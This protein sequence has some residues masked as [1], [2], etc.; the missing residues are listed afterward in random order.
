MQLRRVIEL[1][2]AAAAGFCVLGL[3]LP[4]LLG[5]VT[6]DGQNA[7]VRGEV[8]A[9]LGYVCMAIALVLAIGIGQSRSKPLR[10]I[11][12][13]GLLAWLSLKLI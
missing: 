1:A 2:V 11:G 9:G 4:N 13:V 12:W 10:I 5:P 3:S 6:R 7:E 8:V